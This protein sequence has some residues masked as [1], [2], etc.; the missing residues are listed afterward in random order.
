MNLGLDL[1]NAFMGVFVVSSALILIFRPQALRYGLVDTPGGHKSHEEPTPLVGGL[2]MFLGF[3]LFGLLL[4]APD[5]QTQVLFLSAGAL[6][7]VGVIDDAHHLV[8]TQRI[9]AQVVA[10][11]LVVI[12]GDV[13][14]VDLGYFSGSQLFVLGSGATVFSIFAMVGGINA[15]NM[16]DGIDGLAGSLA[17]VT[18]SLLAFVAWHAGLQLELNLIVILIGAVVAFLAFNI[19]NRWRKQASVFMGDAGSMFLGFVI[20]WLMTRLSQGEYRA[21]HPVTALW[22]F[23]VPLFDAVSIIIGRVLLAKSPFTADRMH[24]HHI[25]MD[26]GFDVRKTVMVLVMLSMI[27]GLV[28]LVGLY[29]KVPDFIMFTCFMTLFGLYFYR[30]THLRRLTERGKKL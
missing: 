29:A 24:L 15:M 9:L 17:L 22:I 30:V 6:V 14:V 25:L 18:L 20:A 5:L 23:A 2:S 4:T 1:L 11:G 28:G 7:V 21:M 27:F 8:W 13:V 12:A 26:E 19:P 3:L 10:A 16:A